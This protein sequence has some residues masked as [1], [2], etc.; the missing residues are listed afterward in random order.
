MPESSDPKPREAEAHDEPE[1]KAEISVEEFHQ[2]SDA[3]LDTL[4]ARLELRSEEKADIE[5]DY[6]VS[7]LLE[8]R[9]TV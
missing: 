6:S 2:H 3:F 5:I 1:A 7:T 4:L 9:R 8:A